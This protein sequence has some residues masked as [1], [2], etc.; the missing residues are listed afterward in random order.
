MRFDASAFRFETSATERMRLTSTGLG[1]G[2]TA[3]T[4]S[5]GSTGLHVN[6]SGAG[7]SRIHLTDGTTGELASDGTE[8]AVAGGDFYI[9]QKEAKSVIVFTNGSERARIDSSGRLLVGTSSSSKNCK[10]VIQGSSS[11]NSSIVRFCR[12]DATPGTND[13]LSALI[14]GD[15][16]QTDAAYILVNRD[17]GTWTSGSSHP[18]RL[19]FSTTADGESSPT[20]RMRIQNSGYINTYSTSNGFVANVSAGAGTST[21]LYAGNRSSTNIDGSGGITV[22]YVYSNGTVQNATGTYTTISDLKLK[23][24]IVDASSQWD[25]LKAIQIRNWN[26]KEETGHETHRQL[27]P[28]AQE[29]ERVCPG[30]VFETP[31]RDA[32][33]NDLGTTTKGVN[34]SVLYMK[35]VK[36]LQEAMERIEQLETEMAAVKAQLS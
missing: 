35:A 23:E 24:N 28:I 32:E 3:P 9:D 21:F 12:A 33:G 17:G 36:A 30:L 31:D 22:Y 20:A 13:E 1:I 4:L 2:T 5:T 16:N 11:T 6:G 26:F 25:D 27:G 7:G 10:L 14:F 34:Q 15:S 29:L 19:T 8:L 18:S